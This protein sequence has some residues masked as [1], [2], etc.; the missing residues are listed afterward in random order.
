MTGWFTG[1]DEALAWLRAR[2]PEARAERPLLL[3]GPAGI[4]KSAFA[5]H[6]AAQADLP[7]VTLSAN[8]GG[9][10][11]ETLRDFLWSLA[12][13]I[14]L[15]LAGRTFEAP[16]LEKSAL[17]LN[18]KRNFERAFWQP[19]MKQLSAHR[20]LFIGDQMDAFIRPN[21]ELDSLLLP[22]LYTLLGQHDNL[23]PLWLLRTRPAA[24]AAEDLAP[25]ECGPTFVLGPL[26]PHESAALLGNI[27]GTALPD[28]MAS[29]VYE[30]T[31]GHPADLTLIGQGL[32]A[33]RQ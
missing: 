19:L 13:A 20:V 18:P 1:R 30:L 5:G 27:I 3:S 8:L 21:S 32:E 31:R 12:E 26:E 22:Y 15:S 17:V 9:F 25:F 10:R 4:G 23:A 14:R 33:R 11:R 2:L 28:Q 7:A 24:L 6:L 29:Y 16:Q